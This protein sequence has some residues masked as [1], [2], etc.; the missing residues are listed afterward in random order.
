MIASGF[1]RLW[2]RYIDPL[3]IHDYDQPVSEEVTKAMRR[4]RAKDHVFYPSIYTAPNFFWGH[5]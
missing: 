2:F 3:V 1:F 4:V 5:G